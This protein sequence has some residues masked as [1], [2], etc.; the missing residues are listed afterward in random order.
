MERILQ[1]FKDLYIGD[2]I[3][4]KHF[5][6]SVLFILPSLLGAVANFMDKDTPKTAMV[7]ILIAFAVLLVLSIIPGIYLLGYWV[8]FCADRIGG[9]KGIPQLNN[10]MFVEGLKILP[11]AI[12]WGIYLI[13]F[14][15][16]MILLPFVPFIPYFSELKSN[17]A[18]IIAMIVL[19][20]IFYLLLMLILLVVCPFLS[21]VSIKYVKQGKLS[22]DL[23]NPLIIFSF[24]KKSFKETIIVAIK[25]IL[26]NIVTNL[27]TALLNGILGLVIVVIVFIAALFA[28]TETKAEA[29]MYTPLVVMMI[30]PIATLMG[31]IQTYVT[32]M[33]GYASTDVYVDIY[34]E[35]IE[36]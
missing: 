10:Q 8:R 15:T 1:S 5:M 30:L 3:V 11:L 35:K 31:I 13:V 23:F 24:M 21:Y 19:F 17:P 25:F 22:L 14:F 2:E 27:A 12:V 34:N 7:V 29:V 16:A 26:V 33:V 18:L 6:L 28:P 4:K 32:T 36:A 20:C 9:I